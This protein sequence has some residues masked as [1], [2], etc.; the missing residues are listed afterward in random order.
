MDYQKPP[1]S[2]G[3]P[4]HPLINQPGTV[5]DPFANSP[6]YLNLGHHHPLAY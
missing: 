4:T 2:M 1:L 5:P 3:A 6:I